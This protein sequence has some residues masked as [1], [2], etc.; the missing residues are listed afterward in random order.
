MNNYKHYV[1]ILKWKSAEIDALKEISDNSMGYI[2]P[3]FQ[4]LMPVNKYIKELNDPEKQILESTKLFEEKFPEVCNNLISICKDRSVFV[5]CSLLSKENLQKRTIKNFMERLVPE[6]VNL[7]PVINLSSSD[8]LKEI[9]C[10][11]AKR[12]NT[13][14]CLRIVCSDFLDSKVLSD[15]LNKIINEYGLNFSEIDILVDI[16]AIFEDEKKFKDYMKLSQKLPYLEKWRTFIFSSG[17]FPVDLSKYKEGDDILEPRLDWLLWKET[18]KTRGL[19]RSPMFSDYT[20][21]HPIYKM[22]T[23]FMTPSASIKYTLKNNWYILRGGKG[24]Y[25][26]YLANASLLIGTSNFLGEKFSFGDGYINEKG[27]FLTEYLKNKKAGGT[28]NA[29][30]WLKA[31][32]NHHLEYTANQIANLS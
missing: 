14:V 13:G 2:T 11:L 16:K 22:G 3:L 1:P 30:T 4:M 26:Q 21:Q 9:V 27:N 31:T 8:N 15:N 10:A 7:I 24:K 12:L 20:I 6:G 23:Q 5:D 29:T 25:E 19:K 32:I 17:A 28:G 18:I